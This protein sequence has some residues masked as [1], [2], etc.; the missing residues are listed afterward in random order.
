MLAAVTSA[1]VYATVF[2]SA[3]IFRKKEFLVLIF[4]G[5][6]LFIMFFLRRKK[7]Y[8]IALAICIGGVMSFVEYICIKYFNMWRYNFVNNTIPVWLPMAWT[9][10]ALMIMDAAR[11]LK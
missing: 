7:M 6:L 5:A 11:L 8:V 10:V 9:F 3:I 1:C 2:C 4:H